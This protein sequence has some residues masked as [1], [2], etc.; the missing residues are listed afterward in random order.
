MRIIR[1]QK[2]EEERLINFFKDINSKLKGV[3]DKR[4]QS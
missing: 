4:N 2:G 3:T 1:K